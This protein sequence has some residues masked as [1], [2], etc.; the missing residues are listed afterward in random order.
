M[1]PTSRNIS[2]VS[3]V[4]GHIS[5][6]VIG[7]EILTKTK[8]VAYY[9]MEAFLSYSMSCVL[10]QYHICLVLSAEENGYSI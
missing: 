2:I 8:K 1:P 9:A 6:Q 5:Q 3:S 7:N 4:Y 10:R